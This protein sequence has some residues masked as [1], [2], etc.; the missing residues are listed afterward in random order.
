MAPLTA[1]DR[2]P[3]LFWLERDYVRSCVEAL[4]RAGADKDRGI[5]P[6]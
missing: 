2:W 4:L 6:I 5:P 1:A 3:A